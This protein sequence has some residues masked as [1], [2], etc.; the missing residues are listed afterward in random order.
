MKKLIITGEI[1]VVSTRI[2]KPSLGFG[3]IEFI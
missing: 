3:D 2:G 1:S